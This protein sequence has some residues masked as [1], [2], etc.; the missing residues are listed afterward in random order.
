MNRKFRAVVYDGQTV[1]M[2]LISRETH[3]EAKA[4]ME[5]YTKEN[6]GSWTHGTIEPI[7]V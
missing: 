5:G 4:D 3:A 1:V 6:Q 2:V 7:Y